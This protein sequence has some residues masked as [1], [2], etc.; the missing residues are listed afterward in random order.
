MANIMHE[1][2]RKNIVITS[3]IAIFYDVSKWCNI[4]L[5]QYIAIQNAQPWS[6]RRSTSKSLLRLLWGWRGE[7]W[8]VW[9]N[10]N[11]VLQFLPP[12]V[13]WFWMTFQVLLWKIRFARACAKRP[14]RPEE[15]PECWF[16][17]RPALR[18]SFVDISLCNYRI[19]FKISLKYRYR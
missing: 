1:K 4:L 15:S 18:I 6:C 7:C 19:I 8:G 12:L 5:S 2:Y 10:I 13:N 9:S 3:G 11:P 16:D 14:Q 17:C